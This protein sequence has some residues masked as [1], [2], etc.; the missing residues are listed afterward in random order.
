MSLLLGKRDA[1]RKLKT[2]KHD[3]IQ[4]EEK[5]KQ[6]ADDYMFERLK[7]V[8]NDKEGREAIPS[9]DPN[10]PLFEGKAPQGH[11]QPWVFSSSFISQKQTSRGDRGSVLN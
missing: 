8:F 1:R 6:R 11:S 9:D 5:E 2:S 7:D 10:L 3:I 4:A